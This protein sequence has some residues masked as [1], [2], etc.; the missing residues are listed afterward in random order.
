MLSEIPETLQPFAKRIPL[1][2]MLDFEAISFDK[3]F[4]TSAVEGVTDILISSNTSVP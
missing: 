4:K 3:Q 2:D 1:V